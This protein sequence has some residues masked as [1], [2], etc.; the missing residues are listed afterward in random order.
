MKNANAVALQWGFAG[1]W[2]KDEYLY[3]VYSP[4]N[5]IPEA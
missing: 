3:V 5:Q 2:H 1:V 4:V